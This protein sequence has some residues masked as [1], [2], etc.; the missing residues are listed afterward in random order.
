MK[1]FDLAYHHASAHGIVAAVH[2]PDAAAPVPE[3]VLDRLHPGEVAHARTLGGF[4]QV[5]FVGGR[6]A[7][8]LATQ[9]LGLQPPAVL[10]DDRGCPELP[11]ELI[12]SISHK[13]TLAVAM[14][15]RN[16]GATLGVDLE[17]YGPPRLGIMGR[18]LTPRER[19][20]VE[21]LPAD[22][23]WPALL[24]RFSL[25]EAIYKALDP[26]VRRY[27]GFLE[28][29]VDPDTDGGAAVHLQLEGGEGP[30]DLDAQYCW[31]HGRLLSSV[32]VRPVHPGASRPDAREEAGELVAAG[33]E[34]D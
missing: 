12:G 28:A 17:D 22:R 3:E 7:L 1:P 5:S 34:R 15:A 10:P 18:V 13:R 16:H 31:L 20:I 32:R 8:R 2:L 26:W 6:L 21:S 11:E 25:K 19:A 14:V 29:E 33:S 27:V 4:R 23:Q 30:F 24:L 9:Q